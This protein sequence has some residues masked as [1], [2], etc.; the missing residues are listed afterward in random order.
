MS[1]KIYILKCFCNAFIILFVTFSTSFAQD[2]DKYVFTKYFKGEYN[3]FIHNEYLAQYKLHMNTDKFIFEH[4][5]DKTFNLI[6]GSYKNLSNNLVLQT[7]TTSSLELIL[8]FDKIKDYKHTFLMNFDAYRDWGLT[9]S[10]ISFSVY[11]RYYNKSIYTIVL[12]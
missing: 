10:T 4:I 12:K 6:C 11:N 8:K 1:K 3:T 2:C 7:D 9:D 5:T